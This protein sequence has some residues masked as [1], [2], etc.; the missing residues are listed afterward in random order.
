MYYIV[1]YIVDYIVYYR[2]LLL[3][4][5]VYYRAFSVKQHHV[6]LILTLTLTLISVKQHHV[7][8]YY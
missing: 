7:S 2:A 8:L 6:S 5:I 3:W 1:D 4:H